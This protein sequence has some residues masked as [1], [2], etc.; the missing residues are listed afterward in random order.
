VAGDADFPDAKAG[1]PRKIQQLDIEGEPVASARFADA[2][3]AR[4]FA[5]ADNQLRPVLPETLSTSRMRASAFA[6][7]RTIARVRLQPRTLHIAARGRNES[8][9]TASSLYAGTTIDRNGR[10]DT[11][12]AMVH[13]SL[14]AHARPEQ[15]R[16]ARPQ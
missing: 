12:F 15:R 11:M 6:A 14:R 7:S 4:R 16:G 5:R 2:L 1:E 9:M 10:W 8:A 3:C 13:S